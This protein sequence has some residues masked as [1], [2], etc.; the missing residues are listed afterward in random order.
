[1]INMAP[2][3]HYMYLE[4]KNLQNKRTDY[5]WTLYGMTKY[6]SDKYLTKMFTSF[7]FL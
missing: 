5:I 4:E 6:G 3:V 2:V 7:D 1:M